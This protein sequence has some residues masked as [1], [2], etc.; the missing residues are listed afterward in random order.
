[1]CGRY[2]DAVGS[3]LGSQAAHLKGVASSINRYRQ[4]EFTSCL[5]GMQ[6]AHTRAFLRFCTCGRFRI[7]GR[8][9]GRQ[10]DD[11][12]NPEEANELLRVVLVE[13]EALAEQ[14]SPARAEALLEEFEEDV[15]HAFLI[16]DMG[17]VKVVCELYERRF[18]AL[19]GEQ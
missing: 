7:L 13:I 11:L 17:A 14:L 8:Y 1:V 12:W 18:R 3:L 4:F 16:Q 15:G 2:N 19:A 9:V 10:V 6:E 5:R